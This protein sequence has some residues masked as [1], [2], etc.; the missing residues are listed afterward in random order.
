L[1]PALVNHEDELDL[2]SALGAEREASQQILS[3]YLPN[4]DRHGKRFNSKPWCKEAAAIL[5]RVG[6]GATIM[7]PCDGVTLDD[8]G[9]PMMEK[10]IIIFSYVTDRLIEELPRLRGFLHRFGRETSQREVVVE[11]AGAGESWFFRIKQFDEAS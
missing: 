11:L 6:G 7:P 8:S 10:T 5:L 1:Y 2:A 9:R 3:L 4:K